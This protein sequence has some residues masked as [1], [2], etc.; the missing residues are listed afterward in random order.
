MIDSMVQDVPKLQVFFDTGKT[1]VPPEFADKSKALVGYLQS[2]TDVKAIVS[3]FNDPTGDAA[4]NAELSKQR[5][6]AV[7]TALAAA[8]VPVDRTVLEKPAETSD[9]GNTNAASRRVDV[10]L[11]AN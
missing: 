5:A 7:Q 1:E 9:T 10:V 3:G 8:G 4:R 6:M 11:R 2:H